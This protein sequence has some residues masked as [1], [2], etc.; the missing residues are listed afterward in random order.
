MKWLSELLKAWRARNTKPA[1]DLKDDQLDISER[2]ALVQRYRLTSSLEGNLKAFKEMIGP[3]ADITIRLMQLGTKRVPAAIISVEEF[4]DS[5]QRD[6]LV[7]TLTTNLLSGAFQDSPAHKLPEVITRLVVQSPR[8]NYADTLDKLWKLLLEGFTVILIDG[9]E[10]AI[11]CATE[12][13][14]HR[15]LQEPESEPSIRGPRDGFTECLST[16]ISLIR[17]RIRTPNLWAEQFTVGSLTRTRIGVMYIKGLAHEGLIQEIRQRVNRISVDGILESGQIEEFIEDNPTSLFPIVYRTER[18]DRV[19]SVLLEGRIAIFTDGTPFV[20]CVPTEFSM[21]LK[22]PDDYYERVPIGSI[23]GFLRYLSFWASMLL[24]GTYVA[25]LTFHHELV[26]TELLFRIVAAREGVPFPIAMEVF[27]LEFVFEILREAGLRLPKAVGSAVTIVGALVLG[28]AAIGAGLVSPAVVIIISLTAIASFTTANFAF[29]IAAR[30][31]RFVFI[32]LGSLFGLF[33]IQFGF[34]LII[35][36]LTSMRSF[37]YPYFA[38]IGPLVLSDLK[39]VFVRTWW[40]NMVRRP[41]LVGSR[42]PIRQRPGQMPRPG[43]QANRSNK[44]RAS[45]MER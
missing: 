14:V 6:E 27:I 13:V 24:P 34:L 28:D 3:S 21:L 39:D 33:G 42:E 1:G 18:P 37:G 40:W 4:A 35:L 9:H 5:Q 38:P 16:N 15:T 32:V 12:R 30:L 23:I 45:R 10:Q 25:T 43:L 7:H 44:Q 36:I 29:S 41:S 31:L 11:G 22:A 26:P 2:E 17:R 8:I 19:A 20:L